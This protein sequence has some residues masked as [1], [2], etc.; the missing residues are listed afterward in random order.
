[1]NLQTQIYNLATALKT[2]LINLDFKLFENSRE[3]TKLDIDGI[4]IEVYYD[5]CDK[6]KLIDLHFMEYQS[7][8]SFNDA[9]QKFIS[10]YIDS[11]PIP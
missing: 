7:I 2:K 8:I 9:E 10:G 3:A 4:I 11:L 1:M 6:F 5:D